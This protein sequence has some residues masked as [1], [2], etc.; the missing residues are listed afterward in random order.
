M[1]KLVDHVL[2][3]TAVGVAVVLLG[4]GVRRVRRRATSR[5][6]DRFL[7]YVSAAI[8]LLAGG[9]GFDGALAPRG[10]AAWGDDGGGEQKSDPRWTEVRQAWDAIHAVPANPGGTDLG[11][12][13]QQWDAAEGTLSQMGEEEVPRRL[14]EF[15]S[16]AA[17]A[18][19]D[20]LRRVQTGEP[21][22]DADRIKHCIRTRLTAARDAAA[23]AA[24]RVAARPWVA[25]WLV[26]DAKAAFAELAPFTLARRLDACGMTR[27]E[28]RALVTDV[29]DRLHAA[30]VVAAPDAAGQ[31]VDVPQAQEEYGV[32]P[33]RPA[34]RKAVPGAGLVR[35][36]ADGVRYRA[37]G[38]T[39][40]DLVPRV[41]IAACA[42]LETEGAR[43]SRIVF[44]NGMVADMGG[45]EIRT[46]W[47][48]EAV[49]PSSPELKRQIDSAIAGL[50]SPSEEERKDAAVILRAFGLAAEPALREAAR[51]GDPQAQAEAARLLAA[52]QALPRQAIL[53]NLTP[54]GA[55]TPRKP[56][57]PEMPVSKYGAQPR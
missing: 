8:V 6:A 22:E 18:R 30:Y 10:G 37:A 49:V 31:A 39:W 4:L 56:L 53:D 38:M 28:Y 15:L 45:D 43:S 11:A 25:D 55:A 29:V 36:V 27:E 3:A 20:G 19:L 17:R 5:I 24:G 48:L 23:Q 12:L 51:G 21:L 50:A 2:F 40:I 7:M 44:D 1:W 41:Q 46:G 57:D 16:T 32:R 14:L 13:A 47:E 26:Q 35:E 33:L 34:I 54:I 9:T 52:V 42:L